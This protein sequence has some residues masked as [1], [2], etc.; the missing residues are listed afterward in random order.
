MP[1]R[2]QP[3]ACTGRA[4]AGQVVCRAMA[5]VGK[6]RTAPR[7]WWAPFDGEIPD[8]ETPGPS[9]SCLGRIIVGIRNRCGHTTVAVMTRLPYRNDGPAAPSD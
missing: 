2:G 8:Y 9:T 5:G 1:T 3:A 4:I 6:W 7:R